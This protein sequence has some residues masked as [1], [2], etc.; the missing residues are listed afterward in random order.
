MIGVFYILSQALG[1]VG[2]ALLVPAAIGMVAGDPAGEVKLKLQLAGANPDYLDARV[3]LGLVY[4]SLG[5]WPQAQAEWEAVVS[6]DPERSD[7][8]MY[9]RLG[10][11]AGE[12]SS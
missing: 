2:F 12:S 1:V 3:Q 9:L 11:R 4:Y 10:E 6:A 5:R 7:A 8:R